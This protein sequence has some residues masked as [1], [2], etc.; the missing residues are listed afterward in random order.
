M[1]PPIKTLLLGMGNPYLS[2]DAVGIR[3]V[4]DFSRRLRSAPDLEV[5]EECS[6]GGL[7]LLDLMEG[8]TR[9]IVVDSIRTRGGIPGRWY[10]FTAEKLRETMN[11]SNIHDA[12]FA[13][14]LEL[15]RRL[16]MTIPSENETHIFAVEIIDNL[17]FS[18]QL[19]DDLERSY[20]AYS[21]EI[22][23]EIRSLIRLEI[24]APPGRQQKL[25]RPGSA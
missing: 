1:D 8:F 21:K 10:R 18:E 17:T 2:D 11:L 9:L 22:F 15:G 13:T 24:P 20:P 25:D 7:N 6:A 14:A 16:G 19:T 23:R 4:R 12:N 5:I 3:L